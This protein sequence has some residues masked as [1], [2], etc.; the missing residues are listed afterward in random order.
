MMENFTFT[1][2]LVN[3]EN[4]DMKKKI[5]KKSVTV[6]SLSHSGHNTYAV[7]DK[8]YDDLGLIR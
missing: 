6:S 3:N 5:Q 8:S 2:L 1:K 7:F 4:N